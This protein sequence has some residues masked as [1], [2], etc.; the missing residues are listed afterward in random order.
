MTTDYRPLNLDTIWSLAW[1]NAKTYALPIIAM[2]IVAYLCT[3]VNGFFF[4][5]AELMSILETAAHN[6]S[7]EEM[8]LAI[9]N[10]VLDNLSMI[11]LGSFIGWLLALYVAMVTNRLLLDGVKG[12]KLEIMKRAGEGVSN[13]F[14]YLGINIVLLF[15]IS[16]GYT[17]FILPGIWLSVRLVFVPIIAANKPEYTLKEAFAESWNITRGHF[18]TLIGYAI[19]AFLINILG[20]ICCCVGY[21]FTHVITQFMLANVYY[22]L[23]YEDEEEVSENEISYN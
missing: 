4:S 15:L 8:Q 14:S 11:C 7:P 22:T 3:Q 6:G 17:L 12:E 21:L 1:D 16:I 18:W 5:T 2:N 20:L 9:V 13:Y 10:F 23:T 19:V